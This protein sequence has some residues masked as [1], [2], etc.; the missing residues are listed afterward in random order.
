MQ[1]CE[2]GLNM[3]SGLSKGYLKK[4]PGALIIQLLAKQAFN[5]IVMY[6]PCVGYPLSGS[7]L[8]GR[9]SRYLG[10]H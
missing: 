7:Q 6:L 3:I 2:K 4:N 9:V 8:P 1:V 10:S 5:A